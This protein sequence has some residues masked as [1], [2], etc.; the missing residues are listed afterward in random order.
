LKNDSIIEIG[1]NDTW[2]NNNF[3]IESGYSRKGINKIGRL[4][5]HCIIFND[6]NILI[7]WKESYP[8]GKKEAEKFCSYYSLPPPEFKENSIITIRYNPQKASAE[9]LCDNNKVNFI[10]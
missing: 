4:I 3:Q 2:I 7:Q 8:I 9:Y 1:I 10:S 5:E 6:W